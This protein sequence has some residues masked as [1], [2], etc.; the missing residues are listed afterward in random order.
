MAG[1]GPHDLDDL[2]HPVGDLGEAAGVDVHIAAVAVDLDAGAVELVLDRGLAGD[3]QRGRGVGGGGGE[4]RE[5]R[6]ADREADLL[7]GVGAAG[8][9]E[10]GGLAEVAD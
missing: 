10:A 2:G 1:E 3:G 9:R 4:H 6:R 5:N 7:Q 8:Q